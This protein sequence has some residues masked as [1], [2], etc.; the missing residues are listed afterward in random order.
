MTNYELRIT[1]HHCPLP[2]AHCQL[3]HTSSS[4]IL[5][6]NIERNVNLRQY[7]DHSRDWRENAYV[8]PV[9][10]RRSGGLSIGINLNPD[11]ACNFDCIYCQVD[12]SGTPRVREVDV[13]RLGDEL[14]RMIA[15]ARG[16]ALFDD[17]AFADVPSQR[18]RIRDFAFSG[19]GEPT[20]CKYF[21]ECVELVA[22]FKHEAEL[23]HAKIV[24]ITDACYL[25][26]PDVVLALA[27]MDQNNGEIW[28]KLDAGTEAYYQR[29]NR[30]NYPLRHVVENIIAAAQVRPVVIQSLFMRLHG[31]APDE[32]ELSA[33]CDRLMEITT[34][35]GRIDYVQVY[36][37]ARRPAESYVTALTDAEVDCIRDL[38]RAKTSLRAESF[39]GGS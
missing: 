8:Y 15:D 26:K 38:V 27:I 39:Y 4:V 22:R 16:G 34:A 20:T 2:I 37:V 19:D 18:R 36:T 5:T 12:R 30:P 14:S 21:R 3:R 32:N 24:L 9:I 6:M 23:D 1:N 7:R 11:T 33:Y 35:G 10:S 13:T 29:V 17:P 31:Q 25:T 28:G